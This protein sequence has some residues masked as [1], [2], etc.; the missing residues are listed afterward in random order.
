MITIFGRGKLKKALAVLVSSCF[1]FSFCFAPSVSAALYAKD[2]VK[3][4][5]QIFENFILPYSYGK[6]TDSNAAN[7][8]RVIVNI[9]DL[10]CHPQV[11]KN[12]SRIIEVFD[13]EY[14]VK[15][16]YL[17]GAYGDVDASW[18]TIEKNENKRK[19]ILEAMLD[20]GRLTG[21]EYY[22]AL[23]GRTDIIK[24]LEAKEPYLENLKT[25][26]LL[27]QEKENI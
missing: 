4:Y 5:K 27:V 20:T 2:A 18:L 19:E 25:F 9:Q 12:I 6:I 11:Q 1:L 3:E 15:N 8:D 22:G 21:A 17:E 10:H 23:N 7:S 14:G 16:V 13:K 24:G 26:G